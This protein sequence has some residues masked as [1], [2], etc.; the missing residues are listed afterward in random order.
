MTDPTYQLAVMVDQLTRPYIHQEQRHYDDGKSA[1]TEWHYTRVPSLLD[2]LRHS[3]PKATGE[4]TQSGGGF[5][6]QPPAHLEALDTEQEIDSQAS[7]WLRNLG[8]DD[9]HGTEGCLQKLHG[10]QVSQDDA[11]RRAITSDIR[12][13]WT[14]ARVTTGWES[15][16]WRPANTCPLCSSK[17]TLRVRVSQQIGHCLSCRESWD[18]STI[19]LLADHIRA[20]NND[21]GEPGDTPTTEVA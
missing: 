17:G 8:E 3:S 5:K 9:S 7:R 18:E 21:T 2:Q 12:R 16:A 1:W 13:W 10:L 19:G 6:S 11:T 20:E 15:P 4:D 14:W